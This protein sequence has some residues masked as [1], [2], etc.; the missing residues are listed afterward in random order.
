MSAQ[1][2]KTTAEAPRTV[3]AKAAPKVRN[4]CVVQGVPRSGEATPGVEKE[5]ERAYEALKVK[6]A[7]GARTER[8]EENSGK[9][10][11][12]KEVPKIIKAYL[13]PPPGNWNEP[14]AKSGVI[15]AHAGFK[16]AEEGAAEV[17]GPEE[18]PRAKAAPKTK[19][20]ET[21]LPRLRAVSKAKMSAQAHIVDNKEVLSSG[22]KEVPSSSSRGDE[23]ETLE[24]GRRIRKERQIEAKRMLE[25]ERIAILDAE[26]DRQVRM[27]EAK[28]MIEEEERAWQ[29][30]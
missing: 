10:D 20:G 30:M 24:E 25:E 2:A 15:K 3:E 1:N 13:R 7:P 6:A 5:A 18:A 29:E 26:A 4:A 9:M 23:E 11:Q 22:N 19:E 8:Q 16:E 14:R 17:K 28:R 27:K 12:G 21:H